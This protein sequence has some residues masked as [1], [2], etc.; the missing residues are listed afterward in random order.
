MLKPGDT[1]TVKFTTNVH[2]SVVFYNGVSGAPR[3]IREGRAK[4]EARAEGLRSRRFINMQLPRTAIGTNKDKTKIYIVAVESSA[5]SIRKVGASLWNL[6]K[7][8]EEVGV[9]DA[10]NLDGGGS[11][12]MVIGGKNVLLP[13]KPYISRRISV[14]LGVILD[15]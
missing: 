6:T 11:T 13:E 14:G 10:M 5:R 1:I 4:H 2:D 8:M 15:K 7:I 12:L 3:L 9:Y